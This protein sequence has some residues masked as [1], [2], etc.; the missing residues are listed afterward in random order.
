M[1][2][3]YLDYY[4]SRHKPTSKH[5][6]CEFKIKPAKGV[7][8]K[9]A[10]CAV[11]AESSV[12]TWTKVTTA[13]KHTWSIRARVF[14]LSKGK[15]FVSYPEILFEKGNM[16]QIL[17]S[18]AGNIFGMKAVES[19]RLEDVIFTK[20]IVKSFKG[21]RFGLHGVRKKLKV[22]D[23]PLLGTI[24]KPK[25]GLGPKQH[26][27]VAYEAWY[28]G[29][30]LVKD[31]ENLSSQRFNPFKER[32][33]R[34]L[35]KQDLAEEETGERKAYMPNITAEVDEMLDRLDF[36][37]EHGGKYVMVD[38]LTAGFSA[39][40]TVRE[41]SKGLIIHAHRAMHAAVTRNKAHG[42]SM[43]VLAKVFR[44]IG[45]DQLHTGTIVGK[46]EGG[47]KEVQEINRALKAKMHGLKPVFPVASGGLSPVHVPSLI[48]YL[49]K[50]VI[51]Q[52]GGG[53]H[54]HPDGTVAGAMAARQAIEAVM[55][56][57][58]LKEYAEDNIE[59]RHAL[60]KWG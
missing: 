31:D 6:V 14:K 41:N 4:D 19:L 33:V 3:V 22:K 53:I 16:P 15:A 7:S 40:Q 46:M 23:R 34:T 49:G 10:A 29:C 37:R 50:D 11:A 45:V 28:G 35:E 55:N 27:E 5:L 48:K 18:I 17:S 9:E 12:G 44:L 60:I 59:L 36:V 13:T 57:V 43:L 26:S 39:V 25:I 2:N 20:G 56:G 8:L 1:S 24:V 47:K 52:M 32:I 38:V 30:D 42:V 51:I 21:P 54:G 58:S